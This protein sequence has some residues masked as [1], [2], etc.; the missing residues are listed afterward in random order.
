MRA[1]DIAGTWLTIDTFLDKRPYFFTFLVSLLHDLTGFRLANLFALNVALAFLT[2]ALTFW[3]VRALTGRIGPALLAVA[4]LATLPLFGQ[5]ATGASMELHNL[6]MIAVVMACAILYLQA[7]DANRLSLLVLGAVLL[8]QCRYESVL[9]VVPVAIV[10]LVGWVRA[11]RTL[12]PWPVLAAPLLLI[13]YALQD[14]FVNSKPV[15]WQLHEGDTG[16][17]AWRYLANNLDGARHFFFSVSPGQ[18]SSLCLTLLGL[19][20]VTWALVSIARRWRAKERTPWPAP[21]VVLA[22][23]ALTVTANLALLMFYYWSRID[24]PVTT[25]FALPFCFMLALVAGWVVHAFELRRL[26]ALRIATLGLG[27]WLLGCAS[28]AYAHR[29][30]TQQNLVMHEVIWELEQISALPT[31]LLVITGKASMPYLLHRIPAINMAIARA[32]GP[33]I[34]WH[35]RQGTFHD[36]FVTQVLRPTSGNGDI[37]VDPEDELPASFHLE[38]V[39]TKRFGGRWIQISRITAI[40]LAPATVGEQ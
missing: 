31:P 4:L 9:F 38:P 23:F 13:P 5:N 6:A 28:R 10:I 26:P 39:A 18:T 1:Y 2:L 37:I 35:I 7:P 40:D 16:R 24:E 8:A 33:D 14:R 27:V 25:R 3:M 30:Y 19:A 29:I 21:H 17:F 12:M 11:R 32:R 15:L 20:G 36:V 22:L 34:A